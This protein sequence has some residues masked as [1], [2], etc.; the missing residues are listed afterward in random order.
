MDNDT[1]LKVKPS[2]K[3]FPDTPSCRRIVTELRPCFA[4]C[5]VLG[6]IDCVF[7]YSSPGAISHG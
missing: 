2:G 6:S 5:N 7:D 1:T 3:W 4:Q